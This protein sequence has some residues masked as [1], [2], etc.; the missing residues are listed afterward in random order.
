MIPAL[1]TRLSIFLCFSET[2]EAADRMEANEL[3]SRFKVSTL[4]L[5]FLCVWC[6]RKVGQIFV[7]F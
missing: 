4:K 6:T 5:V 7:D 2:S 1:R 3:R